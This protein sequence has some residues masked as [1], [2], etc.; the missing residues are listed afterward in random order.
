MDAREQ[1]YRREQ[2]RRKRRKERRRR[3]FMWLL[4]T[5]FIAVF[6]V[7]G[8]K[9]FTEVYT[10]HK[11]S[12]ALSDIALKV[13][14][15][16][17]QSLNASVEQPVGE[18]A[19]LVILPEYQALYN[20]NNDF[21]G[22]LTIDGTVVDYP[23]MH[24]PDDPEKYLHLAYDGTYSFSGVPF[25][26]ANCELNCGNYIVYGH[27]MKNGSM[28]AT[29]PKYADP[30]YLEAHPTV[31][32]D[33][34]YDRGTYQVIAAFYSK[35]YPRTVEGVFRYYDYC[36]LD[37]PEIFDEYVAQVKEAAIYDTGITAEY[38]DQLLTLSTCNY[39]TDDGRFVVVAKRITD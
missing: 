12:S 22:W 3:R 37:S 11:E 31:K 36:R 19:P 8:Y 15:A 33:T 26:S 16:R 30:E 32:F 9:V 23:V 13:R 10:A 24:T 17:K 5:L 21:F 39:H 28:F 38:G 6:C 25:L 20:E 18:D 34:L 14:E 7:A 29:L 1:R 27:H 4:L 2:A 35:I